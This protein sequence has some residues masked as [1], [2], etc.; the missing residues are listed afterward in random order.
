LKEGSEHVLG[1]NLKEGSEHV[2]GI[3]FEG[4]IRTPSRG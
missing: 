4:R 3:E 2:L 1:V